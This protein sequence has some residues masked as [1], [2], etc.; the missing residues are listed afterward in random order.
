MKNI[1][2]YI[3]VLGLLITLSF[4]FTACNDVEDPPAPNEEELITTVKLTF[5]NA[6]DSSDIRTFTFADPDGEG[7]N[8]PTIM[9]TIRLAANSTYTLTTQ[10]LDES[11]PNDVEDITAEVREEANEHLVC[12]TV[13]GETTLIR[14]DKDGNNLELGLNADVTTKNSGSESFTVSLKHQPSIKNGT[15]DVGETDVE[16]TF[17]LEI[18]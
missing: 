17:V 1:K 2:T 15:C 14:T 4:S 9:D 11:D 8:A 6:A 12:Y 18:E 16:V 13:S 5:T 10:F 7:G 3:T